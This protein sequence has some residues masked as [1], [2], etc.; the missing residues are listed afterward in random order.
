MYSQNC[1]LPATFARFVGQPTSKVWVPSV[2]YP[3]LPCLIVALPMEQDL[4]Q[5]S[6]RLTTGDRWHC[7]GSGDNLRPAEAEAEAESGESVP[8]SM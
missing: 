3:P 4:I 5:W 7:Y 1:E 2:S 8:R 6:K